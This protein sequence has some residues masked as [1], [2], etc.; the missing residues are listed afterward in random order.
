MSVINN[1]PIGGPLTSREGFS[2]GAFSNWLNQIFLILFDV[3]N[4]GPTASRP[5][6][7]MYVGKQYFDVTL[8][9]PIW[10]Q[11]LG[12]TVWVDATGA[13]V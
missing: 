9:I 11:S 10:V 1:P 7:N 12:P 5:T 2:S 6:R 8:G 13:P 3:Q 4:S